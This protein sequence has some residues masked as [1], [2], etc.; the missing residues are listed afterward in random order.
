MAMLKVGGGRGGIYQ[1]TC[2]G[3]A[4]PIRRAR[5]RKGM[6]VKC[7]ALI[8]GVVFGARSLGEPLPRRTFDEEGFVCGNGGMSVV[9]T[10]NFPYRVW[11]C[12]EI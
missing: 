3:V 2:R 4:V 8:D 5:P 9:Y 11:L 10:V 6:A 12:W 1:S 7:I